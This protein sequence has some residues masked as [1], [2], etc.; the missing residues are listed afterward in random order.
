MADAAALEREA[1]VEEAGAV[2]DDVASA[3]R[4][5]A[6]DNALASSEPPRAP[7]A[8]WHQGQAVGS[9]RRR[10]LSP[11][12]AAFERA[13]LD[14]ATSLTEAP[15]PLETIAPPPPPAPEIATSALATLTPLPSS[16]PE[17]PE[18]YQP[19]PP[20]PPVPESAP[21]DAP[22]PTLTPAQVAACAV[23]RDALS[24]LLGIRADQPQGSPEI[25]FKLGSRRQAARFQAFLED[26]ARQELPASVK[27]FLGLSHVYLATQLKPVLLLGRANARRLKALES[28][29]AQCANLDALISGAVTYGALGATVR[30][31]FCEVVEQILDFLRFCSRKDADPALPESVALYVDAVRKRRFATKANGDLDDR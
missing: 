27:G 9:N 16:P 1:I 10:P 15:L 31:A 6:V 24:D 29:L 13:Q 14:L 3:L 11:F 12:E 22:L 19:R 28:G 20:P 26:A 18:S 5:F 25:L 2:E 17:A 8:L 30:E 21:P 4:Q 23:F 7:H